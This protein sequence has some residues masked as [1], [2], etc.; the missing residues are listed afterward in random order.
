MSPLWNFKDK[1]SF[2]RK[3]AKGRSV[4]FEFNRVPKEF[5]E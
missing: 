2:A 5:E 4:S 3:R 1:D